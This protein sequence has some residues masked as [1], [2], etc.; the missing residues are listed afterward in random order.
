M[1]KR[2]QKKQSQSFTIPKELILQAEK[3]RYNPYQ[4]GYGKHK[5][6]TK[7]TR[8]VKYKKGWE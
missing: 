2:R 8:K 6:K 3:P 1:A 7:Y 5:D 4:G